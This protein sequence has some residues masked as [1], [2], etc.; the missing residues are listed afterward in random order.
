MSVQPRQ[1]AA[2][3]QD[4]PGLVLS[5]AGVVLTALLLAVIAKWLLG[6]YSTFEMRGVINTD[7]GEG[8]SGSGQIS[9]KRS[10]E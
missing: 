8:V 3:R 9:S 6:T 5:T 4:A 10:L 2:T 7:R 1:C